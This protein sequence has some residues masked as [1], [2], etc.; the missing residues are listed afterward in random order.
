MSIN[1]KIFN[2]ILIYW[3]KKKKIIDKKTR[4]KKWNP[5]SFWLSWLPRSSRL[6][7]HKHVELKLVLPLKNVAVSLRVQELASLHPQVVL[8]T[9]LL[10]LLTIPTIQMEELLQLLLLW[11]PTVINAFREKFLTRN[12]MLRLLAFPLLRQPLTPAWLDILISLIDLLP[13]PL[14]LW[15]LASI[16]LLD[17]LKTPPLEPVSKLL[18][19]WL[20]MELCCWLFYSPLFSEMIILKWI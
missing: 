4:K 2:L 7:S 1:W 20:P 5:K 15:E 16:V 3:L 9:M 8:Q 17:T 19:P 6:L 18:P 10:V 13:A 14:E 11:P 12:W